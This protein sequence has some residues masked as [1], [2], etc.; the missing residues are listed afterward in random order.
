MSTILEDKKDLATFTEIPHKMHK[1]TRIKEKKQKIFRQK[2][3]IAQIKAGANEN[4]L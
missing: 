1:N 3:S 2:D 4:C